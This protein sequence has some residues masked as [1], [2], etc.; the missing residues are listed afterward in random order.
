MDLTTVSSP[1]VDKRKLKRRVGRGI[2]SGHGKTCGLG[3]KG[4]YASAG[5]RLPSGLFEGGQ[6]PLFRRWPKR[7]FSHATWDK[8][9]AVVNVGDLDQFDANS[10][11]D[12]ASLKDRRLVVGT[13]DHL[14]ILGDGATVLTKK[15]TVRADHFTKAAKAAIEKAGGTCDVI[16][17]PK[18]PVRNK[19]GSKKK[20][21]DAARAAKAPKA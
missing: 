8:T 11:V 6:M 21:L 18:K 17:K 3:H 16:P 1:G 10:T 20:A 9:A 15:L 7:G 13:F 2:G 4:Q 14:R 5:A 12:M 19:M